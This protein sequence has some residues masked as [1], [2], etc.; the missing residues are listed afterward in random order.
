M[1]SQHKDK[2][3]GKLPKLNGLKGLQMIQFVC[4]RH[5]NPY[6]DV[7]TK[8]LDSKFAFS[9]ICY[10][11]ARQD[12]KLRD[13]RCSICVGMKIGHYVNHSEARRI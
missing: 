2:K 11:K 7:A 12:W 4:S 1:A 5:S 8:S 13:I 3:I 9:A 10:R 6:E